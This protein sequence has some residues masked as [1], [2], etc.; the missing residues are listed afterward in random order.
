MFTSPKVLFDSLTAKQLDDFR[1]QIKT[2]G[3]N[4]FDDD[5]EFCLTYFEKYF[6]EELSPEYQEHQ[7]D[8]QKLN[9][10]ITMVGFAKT[11]KLK[12]ALISNL[13]HN[14]LKLTIR[15]D[16]FREDLFKEYLDMP[17]EEN[18]SQQNESAMNHRKNLNNRSRHNWIQSL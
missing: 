18:S 17:L 2:K 10:L 16:D 4:V 9:N 12:D 3:R 8:T 14:A 1:N 5:E 7:S 6:A 15:L 11:N 13:L